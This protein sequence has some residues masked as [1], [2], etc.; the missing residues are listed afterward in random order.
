MNG[1][2]RPQQLRQEQTARFRGPMSSLPFSKRH[3]FVYDR[4]HQLL[5]INLS[6]LGLGY[7]ARRLSNH[8]FWC[9]LV[10]SFFFG[11]GGQSKVLHIRRRTE[12]FVEQCFHSCRRKVY[13]VQSSRSPKFV[14]TRRLLINKYIMWLLVLS[15]PLDQ[16]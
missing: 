3:E 2:Y 6:T 15:M 11:G 10:F 8:L 9:P 5:T 7:P 14:P 4:L 13:F 16:T 1:K 12:L